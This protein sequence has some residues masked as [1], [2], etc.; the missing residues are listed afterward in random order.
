MR[1]NQKRPSVSGGS[2]SRGNNNCTAKTGGDLPSRIISA[3][4]PGGRVTRDHQAD[5]QRTGT[6]ACWT[7]LK[8]FNLPKVPRNIPCCIVELRP[9]YGSLSLQLKKE[10]GG[11]GA[12]GSSKQPNGSWPGGTRRRLRRAGSATHPPWAA[13]K[14]KRGRRAG[15]VWKS[16]SKKAG[17]RR[18]TEQKKRHQADQQ[19]EP[20]HVAANTAE[21]AVL[22]IRFV[23]SWLRAYFPVLWCLVRDSF[24]FLVVLVPSLSG[25]CGG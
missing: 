10:G 25:E 20:A 19:V 12:E 11:S 4:I 5:R 15:A 13:F 23:L 18:Q 16:L 22:R 2:S 7:T 17:R 24:L 6:N 3:T 14:A 8:C 9:C 21:T 1:D